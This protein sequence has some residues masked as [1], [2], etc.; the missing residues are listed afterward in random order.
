MS[1]KTPCWVC[2]YQQIGG[3]SF[4]G[5]CRWFEEHGQPKKE[6]P[7]TVVDVGCK[8]WKERGA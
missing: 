8:W 5:V 7:P 4:L 6:I 3:G 1:A 2:A